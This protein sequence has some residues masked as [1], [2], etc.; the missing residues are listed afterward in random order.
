MHQNPNVSGQAFPG[1]APTMSAEQMKAIIMQQQMQM[2]QM[3]QMQQMQQAQPQQMPN[4]QTTVTQTFGGM[5]MHPKVD[6]G[7]VKKISITSLVFS[8]IVTI[9]FW[10]ITETTAFGFE[11]KTTVGHK[12][13]YSLNEDSYQSYDDGEDFIISMG[14]RMISISA[15]MLVAACVFAFIARHNVS[16]LAKSVGQPPSCC[17]VVLIVFFVFSTLSLMG[18]HGV[19]MIFDIMVY[20]DYDYY[21]DSDYA[22]YNSM[23]NSVNYTKTFC[24]LYQLLT[25]SVYCYGAFNTKAA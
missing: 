16:S 20:D 3:S 12:I 4:Q 6:V 5:P 17:N 11:Y 2:Q 25:S 18:Y 14:L 9:W 19:T 13:I 15:V 24:I 22:F 7:H 23:Q 10:T 8:L 1:G 21:N